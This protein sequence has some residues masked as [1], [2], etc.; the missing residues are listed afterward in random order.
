ME[1]PQLNSE[2]RDHGSLQTV[3]GDQSLVR[4]L[5]RMK[6]NCAL[7]DQFPISIHS[8]GCILSM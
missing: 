2:M 4:M 1:E 6:I 8:T 5:R 7:K 3:L